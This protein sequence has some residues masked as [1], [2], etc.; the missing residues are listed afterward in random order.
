MDI[1][2]TRV[3]VVCRE[4]KKMDM[5]SED[6]QAKIRDIQLLRV[7]KELQ[8]FLSEGDQQ[9]RQQQEIETLEKTLTLQE[10]VS[11]S[12]TETQNIKKWVTSN[13]KEMKEHREMWKRLQVYFANG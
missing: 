2:I 5:Q 9:A 12:C 7:T 11:D 6:L 3:S 13:L 4:H 8:Q 1:T 10:K